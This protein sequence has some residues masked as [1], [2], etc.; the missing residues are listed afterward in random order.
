M[1]WVDNSYYLSG[2]AK[3]LDDHGN[4]LDAFVYMSNDTD[5]EIFGHKNTFFISNLIPSFA[6]IEF[7]EYCKTYLNFKYIIIWLLQEPNHFS[8]VN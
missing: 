1:P 6:L 5:R 4:Y 3:D 2:F 7:T 8:S